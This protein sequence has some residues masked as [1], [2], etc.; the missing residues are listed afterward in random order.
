MAVSIS[1]VTTQ[2]AHI[3]FARIGIV[4]EEVF[5]GDEAEHGVTKIFKALVVVFCFQIFVAEGGV[6]ECK[7]Q[8]RLFLE[9]VS[10]RLF[11]FLARNWFSRYPWAQ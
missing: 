9:P 8:H 3:A 10:D 6:R 11:E 2:L 5:G 1:V 4:V 7:F